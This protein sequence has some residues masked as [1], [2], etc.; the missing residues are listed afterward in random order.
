ME[1]KM[2]LK[3]PQADSTPLRLRDGGSELQEALFTSSSSEHALCRGFDHLL[4]G[5]RPRDP[6]ALSCNQGESGPGLKV[7]SEREVAQAC[8]TLCYPVDRSLPG[9]SIHGILQ[10]RV[11]EWVAIF[12][13]RRSSQPRDRTPVSHI[14]GRRYNLSHQGSPA[15]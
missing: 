1:R 12:F 13:S 5:I 10:A 3:H 6:A 4:S 9:S 14:P 15:L 8:P 7:K 2:G 11:L